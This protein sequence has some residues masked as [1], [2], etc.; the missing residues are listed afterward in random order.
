MKE[1]R[2]CIVGVAVQRMEG[3]A[4]CEQ[5]WRRRNVLGFRM[6]GA[7]GALSVICGGGFHH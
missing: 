6:L 7:S 2:V 3:S 5:A 4:V 1:R